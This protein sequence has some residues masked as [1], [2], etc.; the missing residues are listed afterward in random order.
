MLG[1]GKRREDSLE[2]KRVL[3]WMFL[4]RAEEDNDTAFHTHKCFDMQNIY[5]QKRREG[6]KVLT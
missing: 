6:G 4:A 5:M 1:V 2:S 3:L